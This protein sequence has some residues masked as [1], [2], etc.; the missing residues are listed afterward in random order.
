METGFVGALLAIATV[1]AAGFA[2]GFLCR[3]AI[4]WQRRKRYLQGQW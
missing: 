4:S 3:S 2:A 1:F